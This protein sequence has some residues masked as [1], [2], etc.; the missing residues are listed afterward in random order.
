MAY[1]KGPDTLTATQKCALRAMG[2]EI[3]FDFN[4]LEDAY[5]SLIEILNGIE[6]SEDFILTAINLANNTSSKSSRTLIVIAA[7]MALLTEYGTGATIHEYP[8]KDL[9]DLILSST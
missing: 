7:L 8:Y 3:P 6:E 9:L 1:Y 5:K 2:F 4:N